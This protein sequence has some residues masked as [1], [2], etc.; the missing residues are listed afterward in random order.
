MRT[1]I[2]TT[3]LNSYTPHLPLLPL[4]SKSPCQQAPTT[5]SLHPDG[6]PHIAETL[7]LTEQTSPPHNCPKDF[8]YF[9]RNQ[10]TRLCK[11]P[12][13]PMCK[14][15]M[16]CVCCVIRLIK[17]KQ[18]HGHE[19]KKTMIVTYSP[20]PPTPPQVSVSGEGRFNGIIIMRRQVC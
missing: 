16:A 15:H 18:S 4:Y 10:T 19:G 20:N 3:L 2:N 17:Q 1:C 8:L 13:P 12:E 5:R 6:P 11:S 14:R 9:T 7:R